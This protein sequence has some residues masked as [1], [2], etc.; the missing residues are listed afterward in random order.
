MTGMTAHRTVSMLDLLFGSGPNCD[1]GD[2]VFQSFWVIVRCRAP[3][4]FLKSISRVPVPAPG[5]FRRWLVGGYLTEQKA[6]ESRHVNSFSTCRLK[7]PQAASGQLCLEC[8]SCPRWVNA[9][10]ALQHAH[11]AKGHLRSSGVALASCAKTASGQPVQGASL[12]A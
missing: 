9:A 7:S 12:K 11:V 2:P 8:L 1:G 6:A 10:I 4:A 3:D 5:A